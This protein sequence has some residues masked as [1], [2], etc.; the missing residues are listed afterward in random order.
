MPKQTPVQRRE[1]R[2]DRH[3][4]TSLIQAQAGSLQKAI[5]EAVANALD[6]GASQVKVDLTP[7]RVVIEDDGKGFKTL[8]EIDSFFDNFG[9][10]HSQ[11]DRTV[12]RFGVGRGQLFNFGKNL[13]TTHGHTMSVDHRTDGFGYDLGTAKKAH[14]GVKIEIDFYEPLSFSDLSSTEAEFRRLVKFSTIPV[15]FNGKAIQKSPSK[16]KW[17]AETDDAWFLFDDSY[18]LKIYSQ[19]LYVQELSSHRYGKGGVVVTKTGKALTQNMARNDMLTSQCPVWKRVDGQLKK[20]SGTHKAKAKKSH[21][22]T[23]SMRASL[24][25]DALHGDTDESL[26]TLCKTPLFT[27]SNGKHVRLAHLLSTGFVAVAASNDPGADLLIQRKQAFSITPGTLHRFGVS[28]IEQLASR[29]RDTLDRH[30][31]RAHDLRQN[32][33][34]SGQWKECWERQKMINEPKSALAKCKFH[35]KLSDLPMRADVSLIEVMASE[36][37]AEEKKVLAQIRKN[38]LPSLSYQA[39]RYLEDEGMQ[40]SDRGT[41][42]TLALASSDAFSACTDGASKIWIERSFLK[43]CISQGATGFVSLANVLLHEL[44]HDIDT[45]T[46]H[47]HDQAFFEAFH[48]ATLHGRVSELAL[49]QYRTF[50]KNGGRAPARNIKQ[51]EEADMF[52]TEE[53]VGRMDAIRNKGAKP[54]FV[55]SEVE[56]VAVEQVAASSRPRRRPR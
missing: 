43:N 37:S 6:A 41:L 56:Q 9:F 35:A 19:G 24:A 4:L 17:D 48:H 36:Y 11:L 34:Q 18:G 54:E 26:E 21:V 42:R 29:L 31:A 53:A 40:R 14:K 55:E 52:G 13:W 32:C 44:L 39:V 51:M 7:E 50:L 23:E 15:I 8:E 20:L 16:V 1:F 25:K 33:N 46:G 10:D 5:L 49:A 30:D 3:A 45:S 47:S 27:L 38:M 12:G 22:L 2:V 28:N